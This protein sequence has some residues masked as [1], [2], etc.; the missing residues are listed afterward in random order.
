MNV[1]IMSLE[2]DKY[3]NIYYKY[4]DDFYYIDI[5][6]AIISKHHTVDI[7][8]DEPKCKLQ[9]IIENDKLLSVGVRLT[10]S[11]YTYTFNHIY[12]LTREQYVDNFKRDK[13]KRYNIAKWRKRDI[14]MDIEISKEKIEKLNKEIK[15]IDKKK[16]KI[17]K[18][19]IKECLANKDIRMS[20]LSKSPLDKVINF[21]L[22]QKT[23][24]K[25]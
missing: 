8:D 4:N 7:G 16:Y 2:D 21:V 15:Q 19:M 11:K 10:K 18:V 14:E 6:K 22:N 20:N 25:C 24:K 9:K 1:N 23:F 12:P 5:D 13:L 3:H 17:T